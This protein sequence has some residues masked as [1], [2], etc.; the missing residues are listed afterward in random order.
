MAWEQ[1]H[2]TAGNPAPALLWLSTP[3][4]HARR[5]NKAVY[6]FLQHRKHYSIADY[7]KEI[8]QGQILVQAFN[9]VIMVGVNFIYQ[10]SNADMLANILQLVNQIN[11]TNVVLQDV[12]TL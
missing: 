7:C 9:I 1:C 4:E 12:G 5:K 2:D 6:F 11:E 3:I 8:D 10:W